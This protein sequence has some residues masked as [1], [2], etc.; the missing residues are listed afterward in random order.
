MFKAPESEIDLKERS[1]LALAF[2]GD[3]VLELLVRARLVAQ[4][5]LPVGALHR[6]AVQ[7]VSARAQFAALAG[8][9]PL[10]SEAEQ[11]VVR[12]GRNANKTSVAKNATAQEYRAATGLEALFGW[13]YLRDDLPRIEALFAVIWAHYLEK[14]PADEGAAPQP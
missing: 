5:R 9:Q 11:E 14:H 13:L 2:V 10:L 1:P 8:L 4:S 3:G 7:L 6:Q 12:R